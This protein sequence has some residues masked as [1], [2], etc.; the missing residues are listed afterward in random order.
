MVT[1]DWKHELNPNTVGRP[2]GEGRLRDFLATDRSLEERQRLL[3]RSLDRE[4]KEEMCWNRA[5]EER[6]ERFG[7]ERSW[8]QSSA[9]CP[10]EAAL[11]E[12]QKM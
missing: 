11:Y 5:R 1:Q 6:S 7:R 8:P 3:K 12:V 2:Q 4:Y 10:A 9:F